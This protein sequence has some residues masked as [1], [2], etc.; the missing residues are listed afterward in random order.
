MIS[1]KWIVCVKR[2]VCVKLRV[3][4]T[5]ATLVHFG[6]GGIV[7]IEPSFDFYPP[8]VMR[9]SCAKEESV[10]KVDSVCKVESQVL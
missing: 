5:T 3:N 8:S 2:I 7:R 1:L 9:K 6:D 4:L 10:C